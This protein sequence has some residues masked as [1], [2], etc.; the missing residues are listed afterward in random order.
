MNAMN[1]A[2]RQG[3]QGG[4]DEEEAEV[5]CE[6]INFFSFFFFSFLGWGETK[7]TWYLYVGHCLA[8]CTTPG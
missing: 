4:V 5:K 1:I 3:G 8:Y 2:N 7:S 6:I